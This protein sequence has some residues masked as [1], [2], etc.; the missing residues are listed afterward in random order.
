[1]FVCFVIACKITAY[2]GD[3]K[4]ILILFIL[5]TY[6]SLLACNALPSLHIHAPPLLQVELEKDGW[7]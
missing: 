4:L 5:F 3:N 6:L 7:K 2:V 1:L